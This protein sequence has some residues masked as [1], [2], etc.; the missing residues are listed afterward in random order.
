MC[1]DSSA[2]RTTPESASGVEYTATEPM[3]SSRQA[4][5]TRSAIS[6]RFAIRTFWNTCAPALHLVGV[7]EHERLLEL[8]PLAV[9]RRD[10]GDLPGAVGVYLVHQ[11]HRLDDADDLPLVDRVALLDERLR[12][13]LRRAIEGAH[14]RR[15]DRVPVVD[16][17]RRLVLGGCSGSRVRRV[18]DCAHLALDLHAVPAG[19]DRDAAD[20]RPLQ[21]LDQVA[22]LLENVLLAH[23][24]SSGDRT[25]CT[26]GRPK[27]RKRSYRFASS[28]SR[29]SGIRSRSDATIAFFTF[30]AVAAGSSCAPP[31]GSGTTASITPSRSRSRAVSLSAAAARGAAAA[32]LKR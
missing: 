5:A 28:S 6:P 16:L 30:A 24:S 7:E 8:H 1:T 29:D 2:T 18:L 25:G 10:L 19:L 15:E 31:G 32:S 12:P 21:P 27:R 26:P 14:E 11:L 3:P 22:R 20:G 4:R 9:G 13:R 23:P 17:R